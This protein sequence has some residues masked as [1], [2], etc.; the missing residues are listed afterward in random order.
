MMRVRYATFVNLILDREVV[1]E[2]LQEKCTSPLLA[3]AVARLLND[4]RAR[5][6]QIDGAREVALQ[7]GLGRRP[8][9]ERGA[10]VILDFVNRSSRGS[11]DAEPS[12]P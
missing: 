3:E 8:P 5:K 7:L 10:E 11:D 4:G 9:S 6:A 1:P 12:Q 2:L